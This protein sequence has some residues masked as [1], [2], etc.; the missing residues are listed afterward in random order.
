MKPNLLSKLITAL[1]STPFIGNSL[2]NLEAIPSA[3]FNSD[4]TT[5]PMDTSSVSA[6][7]NEKTIHVD[8][9]IPEDTHNNCTTYVDGTGNQDKQV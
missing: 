7:L 3:R 1:R 2:R 8:H 5:D 4:I 9:F 6:P